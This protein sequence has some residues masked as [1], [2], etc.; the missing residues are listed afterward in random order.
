MVPRTEV[1]ALPSRIP[2]SEL[3]GLI[4]EYQHTRYPVFDEN[5]DNIVGIVS[6]KRV[7]SAVATSAGEDFDVRRHMTEPSFV[8]KT[9]RAHQLLATM[10]RERSHMVVAVDEYGTTAG[11]VTLR[12]LISRIAGD[13]PDEAEPAQPDLQWLADGTALVEGLTLLS[14]LEVQLGTHF[15]EPDFDTLGGL[16]FGSLGRRPVVGDVVELGDYTFTVQGVDG[17]RVAQVRIA[18][19]RAGEI[20]AVFLRDSS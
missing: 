6:A 16:I 12:D 4:H 3:V 14:D 9:I 15:A 8:P 13:L 17:L 7:L 19:R 18:P 10:K 11:I 5:L 2:V 20:P 1:V